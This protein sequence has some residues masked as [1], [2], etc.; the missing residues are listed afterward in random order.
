MKTSRF[1]LPLIF[2][3][4]FVY[5]QNAV[6]RAD[7]R[8][9]S[10]EQ[11]TRRAKN[12]FSCADIETALARRKVLSAETCNGFMDYLRKK[13]SPFYTDY[14]NQVKSGLINKNNALQFWMNLLPALDS[15]YDLEQVSFLAS[16]QKTSQPNAP[17]TGGAI[18]HNLDF[19]N[20]TSNGWLGGWNNNA[21]TDPAN[22][23]YGLINTNTSNASGGFNN[24][25]FVHE[26]CTAG[27]DPTV[28]SITRVPPGHTY[29]MRL[30]D[31]VAGNQFNHQTIS[32]TFMVTQQNCT[33]VYWYA[34][35]FD[36]TPGFPHPQTE[37]PFFKIR[38]YNA[39]GNEIICAHYDVDATSGLTNGFQVQDITNGTQGVGMEAVYKNWTQVMIPLINY[40]GQN[41]TIKFESS[42]CNAGA[43]FGYAY[44]AVDC[45]PF[46]VI[47]TTP[48]PCAGGTASL[49]APPGAGTYAW[50][51]P[52]IVGS[53]ATQQI[54]INTPGNYAVTMTTVGNSG[55]LCTF[56]IDT[57][58]I[59][60]SSAPTASFTN[61]TP[62]V[63]AA[64]N[65]TDHS[66]SNIASWSWN[67]GDNSA[68]STTANPSHTYAAAGTYTVVLQVTD[69][70]G[71]KD[72]A[73]RV[74]T[75][76]PLPVVSFTANSV[77]SGAPTTFNNTS[78]PAGSSY[79]WDFGDGSALDYTQNPSHTYASIAT[80]NVHLTV[81]APG[82][83]T[84][85]VTLPV[86][87][88]AGPT[89]SF[90]S[91]AVC[92]GTATNFTDLSPVGTQFSYSW[93]FTNTG[94][95]GS[96]VQNPVYT[97]PAAGTYTAQLTIATLTTP[98]C[99]S[100]VTA[101][102]IV[103]P[104]PQANFVTSSACAGQTTVFDNS[105]STIALPDHIDFYN[106][107][108]GDLNT[109]SGS[110]VSH[111][112]T[113]CD[114]YT[115]TLVVVSNHNCTGTISK[116]VTVNCKPQVNFSAPAVC[117]HQQM[118]FTNT[119]SITPGNIVQWQWNFNSNL[120][121][122]IDDTNQSPGYVYPLA[123]T[124]IVELTATSDSG[125]SNTQ[126][127]SVDVYP[128]PVA[129]FSYT[130]T[131]E[132]SATNF[133][134]LSTISSGIIQSSAWDY[135][136]DN[137]INSTAFNANGTL[138]PFGLHPVHLNVNSDHNCSHDTLKQVY[139]N[140]NPVPTLAVDDPDGCPVH[141]V[142]LSAGV[143]VASVNHPNSIV[144]WEWDM[145][146]NGTADINHNYNPGTNTDLLNYDFNNTQHSAPAYYNIS[147]KITSD[148]GCTGTMTTPDPFITVFPTPVAG[149]SAA[150]DDPEASYSQTFIFSNQA[151]GA[152]AATW[153][154]GDVFVFNPALNVSAQ[155]Q[156]SHNY[157]YENPY[158]YTVHQWVSNQYGCKDST[159]HL[160][161]TMPMWTFYIPNAF[162]PNNDG[163]NEGFR[164]TGLNI[165]SYNLWIFDRW[166]NKI[167]YSTDLD[168]YW[169][170]KVAGKDN[171]V[172]EDVYVWKVRFRDPFGKSHERNGT[173]T[174][175]R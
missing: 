80:F 40:I 86:V 71:C 27:N 153:N 144:K 59:Q 81:V 2:L 149:F 39:A 117:L 33:L 82:G 104:N 41:V 23:F 61:N 107:T 31:G 13:E 83:C 79:T 66:L 139:I 73:I 20:G 90:S 38:M 87:V 1:I 171:I 122:S 109:L 140:P 136:N 155:Y 165:N 28:P 163:H 130:H 133:T 116:Q 84:A 30:G 62:C 4:Q 26:L 161:E 143:T 127:I 170:G 162:T 167:F 150:T 98:A 16:P 151:I 75:V 52:G 57:I 24:I 51:G 166:G 121:A 159:T 115:A 60:N 17:Y 46:Q 58:I 126:T 36:Q 123:G 55:A 141:H 44:L 47:N 100:S 43:H 138:S 174:V 65:F 103:H 14:F 69:N 76:N 89:A 95:I 94:T 114:T 67:F 148:S 54:T 164:G 156:P 135:D 169:D 77:C 49:T 85:A 74:V 125:C 8:E 154:F 118:A 175:V 97:Y 102:V 29:S 101:T 124:Y 42:D 37:Q 158:T 105:T 22:N 7:K 168:Q 63:G 91:T 15:L 56:T 128:I 147:L 173:V 78:T 108:F 111:T 72:T 132:G 93:D 32:N 5:S 25:N 120:D 134:N 11:F 68:L 3:C 99:T 9:L 12:L 172:Q 129:D 146:N 119:S 50:S 18:C 48:F 35:I 19:Y 70:G 106:W 110:N 131:C 45:G 152:N 142:S 113:N 88:N 34:C 145:N 10:S 21:G 157:E 137:T 64:T 6:H 96:T 160:V 92:Q 53:S 112:Y